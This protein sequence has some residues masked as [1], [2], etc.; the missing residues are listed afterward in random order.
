MMIGVLFVLGIANVAANKAVLESGHVMVGTLPPAL[1]ARG[2][3]LA[4]LMEFAVLL[5]AMLFVANGISTVAWFY[6][7]YSIG[8]LGAAWAML[9][10]RV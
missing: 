9:T 3:R 4:L 1:R 5:A 2:G 6:I 7:V 10:G 8:T